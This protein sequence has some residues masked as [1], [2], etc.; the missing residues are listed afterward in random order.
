[1]NIA[2]E[3]GIKSEYLSKEFRLIKPDLENSV[4]GIFPTMLNQLNLDTKINSTD[5]GWVQNNNL[6]KKLEE[7]FP[8]GYDN[9]VLLICDGVGVERL[10]AIG[11][12]VW[13]NINS[14]GTIASTLYPSMTSTVMTSLTYGQYPGDHGLVGYNTYNENIDAIWNSLN[15]KYLDHEYNEQFV[16][17]NHNLDEFVTG[18]PL[19][20]QVQNSYPEVKVS[21][22]GP[23]QLESPSLLDLINR[24]IP[25][26]TY[27]D[28]NEMG[29]KFGQLLGQDAKNHIIAVYI[30][31]ADHFGHV[32]GPE[33]K[34]YTEAIHGINQTV[35]MMKNHPKVVNG[36]TIV[37]MTSDHGQVQI[38]HSISKWMNRLEW[39]EYKEKR[40]TLAT[41]GRVIHAYCEENQMDNSKMLLEEFADGKGL[42]IDQAESMKLSGG[43][44]GYRHRY[45]QFSMLMQDGYLFDIPE[46]VQL[47]EE[48]RLHGQH[49][50]L[51]D[52]ELFVPVGIFGGNS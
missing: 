39:R 40:I 3:F 10:K 1:M 29:K 4:S 41:S 27:E 14:Q 6:A 35:Q 44:D 36:S 32:M 47:G 18:L 28:P 2:D 26:T 5:R 23:S 11:G 43:G 8:S 52:K 30:G 21:F 31:Y 48:M 42:V 24:K 25:V 37:G 20:D 17:E 22:L 46:I 19:I 9:I 16:L 15:L 13:D 51:T 33:S 50:S 12:A 34:E 49:G 45:A 7:S 38:N